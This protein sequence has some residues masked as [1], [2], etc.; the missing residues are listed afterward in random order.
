MEYTNEQRDIIRRIGAV[1][2]EIERTAQAHRIA[3]E[4]AAQNM[5]QAGQSMI[6]AIREMQAAIDRSREAGELQQRYGDLFREF[7]DTL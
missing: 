7:L 3:A 4:N 1:S 2:S 5:A 6:V